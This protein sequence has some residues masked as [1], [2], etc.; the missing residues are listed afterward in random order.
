M[1]KR[2]G[3]S[4]GVRVGLVAAIAAVLCLGLAGSAMANNLDRRTAT[5]FAKSI[6]RHE[7]QDTTGCKD[8]FVRGLHRVS[9]HKAVGKIAVAGRRPGFGFVCTRQLVIKLDHYTGDLD[10]GVSR[11]RCRTFA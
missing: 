7:C 5:N 6:A 9:R 10:Y 8:Y 11:R 1:M 2:S 3:R 4:G